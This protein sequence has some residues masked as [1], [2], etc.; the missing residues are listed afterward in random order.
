MSTDADMSS[1]DT[2]VC[3]FVPSHIRYKGQLELMDTCLTSLVDQSHKADVFVSISFETK[4]F[5]KNFGDIV[6]KKFSPVV[7]FVL[8]REQK[9]QMEHIKIL[10]DR[11]AEKYDLIMFCDDDDRY[12]HDRVEIFCMAYEMG[13]SEAS[14]NN[15]TFM[16]VKEIY[17]EGNGHDL[18][19]QEYWCHGL[20]PQTLLDFFNKNEN[21]C[22]LL[23]HKFAD[24]YFRN[25]IRFTHL[26]D[27]NF[28]WKLWLSNAWGQLYFY[29]TDNPDSLSNE[30]KIGNACKVQ[31]TL[32]FG[33]L[34][35]M[36]HSKYRDECFGRYLTEIANL[37]RPS[38]FSKKCTN[39]E[40]RKWFDS[41]I[42]LAY[43]DRIKKLCDC[44]YEG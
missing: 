24:I 13:Q 16:G 10:T 2:K 41:N 28:L 30:H 27:P 20:K 31:G 22:N 37:K 25:Y 8:S 29:R 3:I 32:D 6:L 19:T 42:P 1:T 7:K 14:E 9:F 33:L 5:Q 35:L 36:N 23:K 38:H 43:Q 18:M 26:N 4:E 21:D 39:K 11:Y 12:R 15:K 40:V 17:D 44:L 34:H